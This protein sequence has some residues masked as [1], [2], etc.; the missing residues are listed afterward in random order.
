MVF[1][2]YTYGSCRYGILTLV[3]TRLP[4]SDLERLKRLFETGVSHGRV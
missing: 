2:K 3:Y 4:L 1:R